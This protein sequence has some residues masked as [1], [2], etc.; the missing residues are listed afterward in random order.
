MALHRCPWRR[1]QEAANGGVDGEA[2]AFPFEGER[3]GLA[4]GAS[5]ERP[6]LSHGGA[7]GG[8][9]VDVEEE[10][11]GFDVGDRR[12]ALVLGGSED[13]VAAVGFRAED[14][15]NDIEGGRREPAGC[16]QVDRA[17]GVVE[18]DAV[19]EQGIGSDE[20]DGR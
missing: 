5:E 7:G 14:D 8:G 3:A 12:F 1:G 16:L 18:A 6:D 4:G 2:L 15:A 17:V 9:A 20:A 19:V 11:S 13:G 10:V